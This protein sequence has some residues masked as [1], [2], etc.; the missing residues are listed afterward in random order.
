M[1]KTIRMMSVVVSLMSLMVF[2]WACGSG[3]TRPT[4]SSTSATG[5]VFTTSPISVTFSMAMDQASVE[6]AFSIVDSGAVSGT[7]AWS[8]DTVT[9]MPDQLWKT[10]HAYTLTI[11]TSAKNTVGTSLNKTF[12]QEF[13][14]RI[15]LHDVN[16]D[17]IDDFMVSSPFH[18]YDASTP[19]AGAAY[20]FLGKPDLTDVDLATQ[21]ADATFT[22]A[23]VS[24]GFA[25]DAKVVGDINGDG[26]ADMMM[27]NPLADTAEGPGRGYLVMVYGSAAP[28]DI[29]I[30]SSDLDVVDGGV[31]GPSDNAFMGWPIKP[32]GD[33]NGDS[34]AD[35]VLGGR[36][37]PSDSQFWLVL[38]QTDAWPKLSAV[39]PITVISDATYSVTGAQIFG[40]MAGFPSAGC[41]VNGDEFDDIVLGSP[42][43]AGGGVS[44]GQVYVISGS[45]TP[46]SLDLRTQAA[47]ET[48]SGAADDSVF[49]GSVACGNING[50]G[51]GDLLIGSPGMDSNRGR[52]YMIAGGPS[53]TDIDLSVDSATA[54]YSG[55]TIDD[56]IGVPSC[57]PGDVNGDGFDDMLVTSPIMT[58]DGA[59][60]RGRAYLFLGASA[61]ASVDLAAGGAADATYTGDVPDAGYFYYFGFCKPV[62]DVNGDGI[63]DIL[64]GAPGAP[65]GGTG[66]G[67]AFVVF[68]STAGPSSIDLTSQAADVTI[69]GAADEDWLLVLPGAL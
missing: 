48:I 53:F 4:I 7:F 14:P 24:A 18:D 49:G 37:P 45:A 16:G 11:T 6:S 44:H 51:Y 32:V 38:G 31:A 36:L 10:N 42:A 8:D 39:S 64:M 12:V 69:T 61:P 22:I 40:G 17:G 56:R 29:T 33:I 63:D 62:G 15:N 52:A 67:Q 65:A 60:F 23:D 46:A 13:T 21:T 66:R 28:A 5:K 59:A 1:N 20:L 35:V 34:L 58:V 55:E 43:A 3:A 27:G 57:I 19:N 47:S 50:D 26:Y 54:V 9:F 41:D 68:G 25:F 2:W 30:T